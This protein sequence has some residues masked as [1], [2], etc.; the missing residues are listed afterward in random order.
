MRFA[1]VAPHPDDEAIACGGSIASWEGEKC[2]IFVKWYGPQRKKEAIASCKILGAEPVFLDSES[3][4]KTVLKNISPELVLSPYLKDDHHYHRHVSKLVR[5]IWKGALWE[6]E[7][8][9]P[10]GKP[11]TAVWFDEEM[12]RKKMKAIAAHKSQCKYRD[13]PK[14]M[15]GYNFWRATVMPSLLEGH[16]SGARQKAKYC[17]AFKVVR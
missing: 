4:L 5:R 6:Y 8:W 3:E 2:C 1:V 14:A 7:T 9:V 10:I 13:W 11:D 16:G 15:K 17:E 12:M